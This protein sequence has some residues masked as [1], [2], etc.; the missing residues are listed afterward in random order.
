[1]DLLLLK[2]NPLQTVLLLADGTPLYHVDTPF[3]LFNHTTTIKKLNGPTQV[4]VA[5]IEWASLQS[6]TIIRVRD[7][8]ITLFKHHIFTTSEVFHASDGRQ[9]KWK[10]DSGNLLLVTDD[11]SRTPLAI[12]VEANLG[13]FST[14]HP[15]SLNIAPQGMPII[16][17]LVATFIYMLHKRRSREDQ[18]RR[19]RRRRMT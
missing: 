2:N 13:L 9:Y 5:S 17:E 14:P 19:R 4:D 3:K 6:Q 8:P 10:M 1:M 7:F 18:D 11:G 15:A 16:D 12:F